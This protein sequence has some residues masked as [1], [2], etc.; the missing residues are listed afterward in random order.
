MGFLIYHNFQF[1]HFPLK[2]QDE[3]WGTDGYT[4]APEQVMPNGSAEQIK[5]GSM[6][7]GRWGYATGI[8]HG[9]RMLITAPTK[10][11]D[12]TTQMRRFYVPV[13]TMTVLQT[14][15]VVAMKATG[16]HDVILENAFVPSYRSILVEDMRETRAKGLAHNTG[17]I[18]RMPLLSY[19]VMACAGPVVGAAEAWLEIVTEVMKVKVGA[20]SG[21]KQQGLMSQK[22]RVARLAMELD[23][24]IRLWAGHIQDLWDQVK[25]N[26]TPSRERRAEIRAVTAHVVKKCYDIIDELARC[27]GSRSFYADSRIQRFHRDMSSLSTHALFE[28]D[29]LSNMYGA[30][31]VGLALPANAMI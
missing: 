12:G 9:D 5:D 21:D 23:A 24:T 25:N 16:R 22:I 15:D 1:G 27:V 4:M 31:R 3:V 6:I 29:H 30:T 19:M 11:T 26:D 8:Q 20:Y 10:M 18:W 28:Y 14:W 13:A 7:S 2:A 17:A